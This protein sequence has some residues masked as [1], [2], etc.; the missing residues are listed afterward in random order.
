MGLSDKLIDEW[1]EVFDEMDV[2]KFTDAPPN[3][4]QAKTLALRLAKIVSVTY[5]GSPVAR[6]AAARTAPKS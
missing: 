6:E 1:E 5:Q 3:H 2:T 4:D